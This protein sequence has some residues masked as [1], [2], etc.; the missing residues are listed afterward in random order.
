[1][2][3][4]ASGRLQQY[5]M[6]MSGALVTCF[7]AARGKWSVAT[8]VSAMVLGNCHGRF[9]AAR[10][11]WSVATASL[12]DPEDGANSSFNAARGKWSVATFAQRPAILLRMRF[13]AARGKW[14]VATW[15]F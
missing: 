6:V 7:N 13:N 5:S 3:H 15:L 2:P 10:G 8:I 9:N 14:S 1:M 12:G 4:A 11:K